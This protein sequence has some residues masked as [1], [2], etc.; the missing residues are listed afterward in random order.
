MMG[1]CQPF[2][3]RMFV[4]Y[5]V[6]GLTSRDGVAM[7]PLGL[8]RG[9]I[10]L[11]RTVSNGGRKRQNTLQMYQT[12]H[13]QRSRSGSHSRERDRTPGAP[14]FVRRYDP[15]RPKP[16]IIFAGRSSQRDRASP[17]KG[18]QRD[19]RTPSPKSSRRQSPAGPADRSC[20]EYAKCQHG[21]DCRF[22][23]NKSSRN[24]AAPSTPRTGDRPV[25]DK[26]MYFGYCYG[27][28]YGKCTAR[29]RK[30]LHQNPPPVRS[31]SRLVPLP[32][33]S[34]K[35]R[36]R[37]PLGHLRPVLPIGRRGVLTAPLKD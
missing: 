25:R 8:S 11:V 23:R 17:G 15:L 20:W 18:S 2:S 33:L 28:V 21:R 35:V 37:R 34:L 6:C 19:R 12:F 24:P 7:R 14:G 4:I 30:Y 29:Q 13:E 27:W 1:C 3:L 16:R 5:A 36:R 22:E 10:R 31:L 26:P 32:V 9:S